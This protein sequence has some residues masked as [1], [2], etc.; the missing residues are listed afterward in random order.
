MQIEIGRI[1]SST[2]LTTPCENTIVGNYISVCE[3][4]LGKHEYESNHLRYSVEHDLS[5]GR[6]SIVTKKK[7]MEI[8]EAFLKA[9]LNGEKVF[10]IDNEHVIIATIKEGIP[11]KGYEDMKNKI[12]ELNEDLNDD[13][14]IKIKE[15][16]ERLLQEESRFADIAFTVTSTPTAC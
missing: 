7:G 8:R 5:I 3:A 15:D 12:K 14:T 16:E 9:A 13:I 10:L 2:V 1:L 11:V 6:F 4:L